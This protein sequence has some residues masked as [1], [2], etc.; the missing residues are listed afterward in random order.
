MP[1]NFPHV[2]EGP[3]PTPQ[4][5][6]PGQPLGNTPEPWLLPVV[7]T[8][9]D[10][11]ST[12]SVPDASDGGSSDGPLHT[13]GVAATRAPTRHSTAG[14]L[15]LTPTQRGRGCSSLKT[16][17]PVPRGTMQ[18][19]TWVQV[20]VQIRRRNTSCIWP[21]Y[22]W[23]TLPGDIVYGGFSHSQVGERQPELD[24][25]P[26]PVAGNP[27]RTRLVHPRGFHPGPLTLRSRAHHQCPASAFLTTWEP[28]QGQAAGSG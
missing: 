25:R 19:R 24:T 28:G 9:K 18:S 4:A 8:E 27:H 22:I 6:G 2:R 17:L 21:P 1:T 20:D 3:E 5:Q 16:G 10:Q 14:R 26:S 7:P 11:W 15:P 13:R 12:S 23:Q